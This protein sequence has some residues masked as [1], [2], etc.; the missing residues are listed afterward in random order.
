MIRRFVGA[1]K[2]IFT[3]HASLH[4]SFKWSHVELSKL[5]SAEYPISVH[6][7]RMIVQNRWRLDPTQDLACICLG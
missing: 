1:D 6:V 4:I 5:R 7:R 2:G 3:R